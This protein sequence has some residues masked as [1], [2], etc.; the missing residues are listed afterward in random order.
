MKFQSTDRF[1]VR[2]LC[3]TMFYSKIIDIWCRISSFF[4]RVRNTH[5]PSLSGLSGHG[6]RILTNFIV[7]M[8][9]L[10]IASQLLL[11]SRVLVKPRL[12]ALFI[13]YCLLNWRRIVIWWINRAQLEVKS[14]FLLWLSLRVSIC[15]RVWK[16][17]RRKRKASIKSWL[18]LRLR[19]IFL[20]SAVDEIVILIRLYFSFMRNMNTLFFRTNT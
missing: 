9:N 13:T 17:V 3:R 14:L 10:K 4:C 11:W 20:I 5:R 12:I 7:H 15:L 19:L 8:M 6:L 18:R 16:I 1:N 2:V